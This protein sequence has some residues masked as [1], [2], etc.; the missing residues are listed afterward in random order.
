MRNALRFALY[1]AFCQPRLLVGA[2]DSN[3][4]IEH[5]ASGSPTVGWTPNPA[6]RGTLALVFSCLA[7]VIASTW[8][9]LHL[10]VPAP[11]DNW[12]MNLRRKVKWM[13]ITILFPEFVLSK[14]ICE[15]RLALADQHSMFE[16]LRNDPRIGRERSYVLDS[17]DGK[18]ETLICRCEWSA[19]FGQAFQCLEW[20]LGLSKSPWADFRKGLRHLRRLLHSSSTNE[21]DSIVINGSNARGRGNDVRYVEKNG[22]VRRWVQRRTWTLVHTYYLNMGGLHVPRLGSFG[23][24]SRPTNVLSTRQI[25]QPEAFPTIDY[26]CLDKSDIEDKSKA[27]WFSKAVAIFQVGW[28][29]VEVLVRVAV[30]LPVTQLEIATA[31]FSV[32]AIFTYAANW[33]KPKGID[34]PTILEVSTSITELEL[35]DLEMFLRRQ[36][37]VSGTTILNNTRR[38]TN[39]TV[40]MSKRVAGLHYILAITSLV[41]GGLHCLAWNFGFPTPAERLLWRVT[42]IASTFLPCLVIGSNIALSCF[43]DHRIALIYEALRDN[44]EPLDDIPD[45]FFGSLFSEA[46]QPTP[47]V[48]SP[49]SPSVIWEDQSQ[50]SADLA[51]FSSWLSHL[52]SAWADFKG[53]DWSTAIDKLEVLSRRTPDAPWEIWDD[54]MKDKAPDLHLQWCK[55]EKTI[56]K[57]F[58]NDLIGGSCC[59]YCHFKVKVD[60][61]FQAESKVKY[62]LDRGGILVTLACSLLYLISRLVLITLGF[63]CLR[64]VPAEVYESTPWARFVPSFS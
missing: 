34:K 20:L 59:L 41:F 49:D 6:R 23:S 55:Y 21:D 32:T 1:V 40:W 17:G 19:D 53:E 2:A 57:T 26:L 7:T 12:Q 51:H 33:W 50:H 27:D 35:P 43:C 4:T 31:A 54:P 9:V 28:L 16:K 52:R 3:A 25:L 42:S 63:L 56:R 60:K 64:S 13:A 5:T 24:R 22:T 18:L 58:E 44:L 15:L 38:V 39:D 11:N 29:L 8:A 48:G 46:P 47:V 37:E 62:N 30:D 61:A 10:N 36:F 14:A 45:K